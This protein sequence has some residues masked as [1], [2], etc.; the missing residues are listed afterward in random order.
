VAPTATPVPPT[1]APT[2]TPR[3]LVKIRTIWGGAASLPIF[4]YQTVGRPENLGLFQE[5]GVEI[6]A[7][8]LEGFSEVFAALAAGHADAANSAPTTIANLLAQ[9]M[10][11]GVTMVYVSSRN[12][13]WEILVDLESTLSTIEDLKGKRI[14]VSSF[15]AST[16]EGMKAMLRETGIDPETEVELIAIGSGAD[17]GNALRTGQV[18][19]FAATTY[20]GAS[21]E[22]FGFEFKTIPLTSTAEKTWGQSIVVSNQILEQ[23]PDAVVGY[24]R[25]IAKGTIFMLEN[26]EACVRLHWRVYPE[27]KPADLSDEEALEKA[28]HLVKRNGAGFVIR[29]EDPLNDWGRIDPA[30]WDAVFELLGVEKADVGQVFTMEFIDE[31]NDFDQEA[32]IEFARSYTVSE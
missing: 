29:P 30:R 7:T 18:D 14:G 28:V 25:A 17:M 15:G 11:P 23:H 13:H 4:C 21:A 12:I 6:E 32:W 19:A 10:D 20:Q 1:A 9:G 2:D 31:V 5:E 26:P 27:S 3:P 22:I 24:L 16:Y 8:G